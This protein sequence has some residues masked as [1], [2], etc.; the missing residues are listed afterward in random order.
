MTE[1]PPASGINDLQLRRVLLL[2]ADDAG[3]DHMPSCLTLTVGA[4]TL[5]E[6]HLRLLRLLGFDYCD[7]CLMVGGGAGLDAIG[8]SVDLPASLRI[9][10]VDTRG[11][12]SFSTF[13][14]YLELGIAHDAG[15]L[16]VNANCYFEQFQLELLL[17][18]GDFS[19]ALIEQRNSIYAH[20]E[21]LLLR[22]QY[23]ADVSH[24][25]PVRI[26][27]YVYYGALY[28]SSADVSHLHPISAERESDQT[29]IAALLGMFNVS[30]LA[31]DVHAPRLE[32][33]Q[34]SRDLI[35]G[36]FAGL[37]H[38]RLVRK[39][40]EGEG[41]AKLISEIRWLQALPQDLRQ[42]FPQIIDYSIGA[43]NS[44][45]TMPYYPF[46]NLRK[47]IICG[48]FDPDETRC[49]LQKILD[50]M[51]SRVYSRHAA[52]QSLSWGEEYISKKHFGRFHA[53]LMYL[54][55][56]EPFR[57]IVRSAEVVINGTAFPNLPSL[58]AELE[59]LQKSRS[60]FIPRQR[61]MIHG[62]LHFQNMLID[63]D[64]GNFIL[65]D[66]RG[67]LEG[68][69]IYYD[70][71]K[72]LHSC[73][74]LYDLIHT[75]LSHARLMSCTQETAVCELVMGDD[76]ALLHTYDAVLNDVLKLLEGHL[77]GTDSWLLQARFSEVMHFASLMYF[78][79]RQDGRETRALC[80]YL[81]AIML[82]HSLLHDLNLPPSCA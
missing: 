32:V 6:Y 56:I 2:A 69:D 51:F 10:R 46:E 9:E 29:Y 61:C 37:H 18:H 43:D 13:C 34:S 66:P 23:I 17:R 55:G 35:G 50:F 60:L 45:F 25:R 52:E 77:G 76:D 28:L 70:L 16:V 11:Q 12:R 7:I 80:L 48:R 36:S 27:R 21:E 3:P 40:A 22:G 78:H 39:H 71:G 49:W 14:R 5:L 1:F 79:L 30:M 57:H 20:E 62:D 38:S 24:A 63:E 59:H 47:K 4:V 26:P 41:N 82:A 81:R 19:S 75:D 64:H 53:R 67:E 44:Y 68:G 58:I 15:L 73:H 74:G 42:Y 33:N 54:R 65:A 72:L 31:I 8:T